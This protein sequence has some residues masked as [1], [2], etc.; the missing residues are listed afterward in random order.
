MSIGDLAIQPGT[1]TIYGIRSSAG[2]L[3]PGGTLHTIDPVTGAATLIGNTVQFRGG[4]LAFAPDGTLFFLEFNELHI[5]DALTA[6]ILS[7]TNLNFDSHDGLAIRSD[8]VFFASQSGPGG[9]A[10]AG[11][12]DANI[13]IID[14]LAGTST[15]L[16]GT[17][18]GNVSDLAFRPIP[19]P[20]ALLLMGLGLAGLGF[21]RRR[22]RSA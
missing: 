16:G 13:R 4:G 22:R 6:S 3:G 10:G 2:A 20:A 12:G 11:A 17:G 9:G 19:E 7:T 21:A 5:L 14:P 8:G 18:A 1:D 15:L